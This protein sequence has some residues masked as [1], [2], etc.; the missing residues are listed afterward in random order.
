MHH[1]AAL[2]GMADAVVAAAS[3][4]GSGHFHSRSWHREHFV[5]VADVQAA[6]QSTEDCTEQPLAGRVAAELTT[7]LHTL[8]GLAEAAVGLGAMEAPVVLG[9][10]CL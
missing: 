5:H 9:L 10:T 4:I 3:A 1:T 6:V 8:P 2:A 7:M